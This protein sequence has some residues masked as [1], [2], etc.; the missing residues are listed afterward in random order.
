MIAGRCGLAVVTWGGGGTTGLRRL[1]LGAARPF[2]LGFVRVVLQS[3]FWSEPH[4]RRAAGVGV[5]ARP[6][7]IVGATRLRDDSVATI[8]HPRRQ[9]IG[10]PFRGM[11]CGTQEDA[12]LAAAVCSRGT[13]GPM[14][15]RAMAVPFA[16]DCSSGRGNATGRTWLVNTRRNSC[17]TSWASF[18]A[19]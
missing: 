10:F 6:G 5:G 12:T 2:R 1:I 8:E 17:S 11:A 19:P 7:E 15:G 16:G 3:V 13:T 4:I 9:R 14:V 18:S